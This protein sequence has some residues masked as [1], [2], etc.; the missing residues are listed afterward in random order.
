MKGF[1]GRA[2][3]PEEWEQGDGGQVFSKGRFSQE[4]KFPP[5][6]EN[7]E[8]IKGLFA[9]TL[10][11]LL[12]RQRK[13]QWVAGDLP[14]VCPPPCPSSLTHPG[15]STSGAGVFMQAEAQPHG[16]S[17]GHT[18]LRTQALK[19]APRL[20]SRLLRGTVVRRT[21]PNV[22]CFARLFARV[23]SRFLALPLH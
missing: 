19:H 2:G 4:G 23:F 17:D 3:L 10:P 20:N 11:V 22:A 9:D 6:P 18:Y 14:L 12:A 7:A 5:V 16:H 21:S 15:S 1:R 13:G 8:L